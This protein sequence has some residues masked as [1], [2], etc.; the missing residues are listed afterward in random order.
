MRII[1]LTSKLNF[2]TAG[3][4]VLDLHLKA[5]GLAELGHEITVITAYSSAN[6]LVENLPYSVIEENIKA[7]GFISLQ[8]EAFRLLRKYQRE[9][10]VFY[11]DGQFFLYGGG[12]FRLLGGRAPV[13]AFFN[14]KLSCW[15]DTRS[16][17]KKQTLF[18]KCK[19]GFRLLLE[20][21]LGVPLANRLDAFIFTTPMVEKI[22]LDFGFKKQKSHILPD[23]VNTEEIIKNRSLTMEDREK[24]QREKRILTIFCS[25]RMIPEKGFDLVI[26]AL[27][28]IKDR[29]KV[30][31]IMGG[32]GPDEDRLRQLSADLNLQSVVY[33]PGWVEKE[34]MV[35]FFNQAQLFILPKWWIEYSSV[36]LIEA[37][38][39][40]LPCLVPAGGGLAWLAGEG[41]PT[42]KENDIRELALRIE[43]MIENKNLR[44]QLGQKNLVK[45][46]TLDYRRLALD[47]ENIFLV[48]KKQPLR[49]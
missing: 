45:A 1:L 27:S 4:S 33:F 18:T 35:D 44:V 23:F 22:Y 19:R 40:G 5:K 47:L 26:R 14:I 17:N 34:K 37:M 38:A 41:A 42:F 49:T 46:K 11:I 30:R 29:S 12:L 16:N 10:D 20:R 43:E 48:T 24:N 32:G 3:G 21:H 13:I 31:L 9:A 15:S 25:G 7:P 6:Y 28:L 39:F 8:K 2:K 36:L